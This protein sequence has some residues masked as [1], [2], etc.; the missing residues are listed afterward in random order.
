LLFQSIQR[1]PRAVTPMVLVTVMVAVTE[2]PATMVVGRVRPSSSEPSPSARKPG[3]PSESSSML[4]PRR[5][6]GRMEW[7]GPFS[8]KRV[9]WSAVAAVV[10][11]EVPVRESA[12]SP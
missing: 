5:K 1:L 11:A 8:L 10:L 4:V 9:R 6:P 12:R 2:E 7:R 3:W